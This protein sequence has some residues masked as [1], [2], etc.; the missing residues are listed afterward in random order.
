M[1]VR[2]V[3]NGSSFE[4]DHSPDI[5]LPRKGE[6]VS[7]DGYTGTVRMIWWGIS[8]K[9]GVTTATVVL[10]Q[11]SPENMPRDSVQEDE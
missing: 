7:I 5:R 8:S 10:D 3:V 11:I 2:Y 1:K 4:I 6:V 9:S